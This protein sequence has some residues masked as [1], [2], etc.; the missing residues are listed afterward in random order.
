[1]GLVTLLLKTPDKD[2]N[3]EIVVGLDWM[4]WLTNGSGKCLYF[5][6][7]FFH[8]IIFGENFIVSVKVPLHSVCLNLNHEKTE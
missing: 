7:L 5:M 1:M 3:F 2:F 6:Q 4:K 8:Y